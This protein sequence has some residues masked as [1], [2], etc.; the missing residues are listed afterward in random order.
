[1]Q[2]ALAGAAAVAAV[3]LISARRRS[4]REDAPDADACCPGAIV[5]MGPSACGKSTLG[6]ALAAQGGWP[7][8]EG[9][10]HHSPRNKAKMA[11]GEPLTEDD[12]APF[13]DSI[14]RAIRDAAHPV[15][16]SCSALRRAHRERLRRYLR[17]ILFVWIDVP[18]GELERRMRHRPGHFMPPSLLDD[19]LAT[20]EPP[21]PPERFVRIDGTLPTADQVQ[22][23]LP[24][25]RDCAKGTT[26]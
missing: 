12:R 2:L 8:I 16:V 9:D 24:Y 10:D 22:A 14:G 17:D 4:M 13:L 18:A 7:T 19:Q 3:L 25:L 21:A 1:M 11:R 20:L 15:V 26:R 5:I 23:L 6:G